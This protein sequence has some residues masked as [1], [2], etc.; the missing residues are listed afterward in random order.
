M[1]CTRLPVALAGLSREHVQDNE[2]M[3]AGSVI[4]VLPVL[5]LFL[6][7][8]APVHGRPARRQRQGMK[9]L[10]PALA[11]VMA[12]A[13]ASGARAQDQLLDDFADPA[14]WTLSATRRR[15]GGASPGRRRPHGSALCIDFDFGKVTGYVSARRSLPIDFPARFEFTLNVRGDAPPNALQFKLVDATGDNVWWGE[16]D[17]LPV[18]ARLAGACG[19]ASETSSSPGARRP[20]ARCDAPPRSSS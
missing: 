17:R 10:L 11:T 3:M 8:A 18:P 13:M 5:L 2:L 19:F 16:P 9:A 7:L 4:T 20:T 15:Q 1:P 12:T 6:A 14:A